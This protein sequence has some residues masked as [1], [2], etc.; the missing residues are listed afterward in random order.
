LVSHLS[1]SKQKTDAIAKKLQKEAKQIE[2]THLQSKSIIRDQ[3]KLRYKN[4]TEEDQKIRFVNEYNTKYPETA[5]GLD[6]YPFDTALDQMTTDHIQLMTQISIL[7][8]SKQALMY[9]L[10]EKQETK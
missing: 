10:M 9:H 2:A 7:T 4:Y 6:D 3:L 8:L 1:L 5:I